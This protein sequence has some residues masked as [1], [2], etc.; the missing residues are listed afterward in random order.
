MKFSAALSALTTLS[1]VGMVASQNTIVDIAAGDEATFGTL[2]AAVTQADLV[3]ALSGEGP[4]T[5]FAPTNDGFA[6]IPE[7]TLTMLLEDQWKPHLT[8][9]LRYHVV[10]GR[11]ASTDLSEGLTAATLL[12]GESLEVTSMAP[13]QINGVDVITADVE[14]SNG[15]IHVVDEVILPPFMS[16]DIVATAQSIDDFST[17]V[18]LVV[19]ADLVEALQEPGLTVFAPTNSAFEALGEETLAT[20]TMP[21]NKQMLTDILLYHVVPGVVVSDQLQDG[22]SVATALTGEEVTVTLDPVQIN[23]VNVVTADVLTSNGVIHVV[24]AV[25]MPPSDADADADDMPPSKEEDVEV[26][27]ADSSSRAASVA[28]GALAL[29]AAMAL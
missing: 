29:V 3:S 8:G 13:V 1:V 16:N 9:I 20:L 14:A 25:I 21:E 5:V 22:A 11:V 2:V 4:F 7:D 27:D 28:V 17:L 24:D 6:A 12:E 15:I 26:G 10:S 18:E 19:A 23:S